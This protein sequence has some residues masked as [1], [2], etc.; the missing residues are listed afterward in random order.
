MKD[1]KSKYNML[2]WFALTIKGIFCMP[3]VI[4]GHASKDVDAMFKRF[5]WRL[6]ILEHE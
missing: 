1:N 2:F 4:V 3:F 5:G 6:K